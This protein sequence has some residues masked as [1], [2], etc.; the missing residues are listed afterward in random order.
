VTETEPNGNST[1]NVTE[2][3]QNGRVSGYVNIVTL[4]EGN[5]TTTTTINLDNSRQATSSVTVAEY[6][7]QTATP[8]ESGLSTA[9]IIA[10]IIAIIALIVA[11][12]YG[13]KHHQNKKK[14]SDSYHHHH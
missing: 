9:A 14:K 7:T 6:K 2:Y 11:C 5:V 1:T 3:D 8:A 12:Y 4:V 10:I 13:Y